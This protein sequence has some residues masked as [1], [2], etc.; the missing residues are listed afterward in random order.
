MQTHMQKVSTLQYGVHILL[1]LQGT[2]LKDC[3]N[4]RRKVEEMIQTKR[5]MVQDGDPQNETKNPLPEHN[6]TL[7]RNDI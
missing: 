6:D 4:L 7:Q 5:I 3:R 1:M 2:V